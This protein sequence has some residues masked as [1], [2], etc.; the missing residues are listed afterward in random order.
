[1][2]PAASAYDRGKITR[3]AHRQLAEAAAASAASAASA[4]DP[5][6]PA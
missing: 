2:R 4:D 5:G 3:A 1:M 6:G